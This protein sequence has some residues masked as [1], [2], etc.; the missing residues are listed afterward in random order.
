MPKLR[1]YSRRKRNAGRKDENVYIFIF[2]SV[3]DYEPKTARKRVNCVSPK[4]NRQRHARQDNFVLCRGIQFY[5][6]AYNYLYTLGLARLGNL[7]SEAGGRQIPCVHIFSGFAI[8][9]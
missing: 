1:G 9:S 6:K 4:Y 5:S 2:V 7:A 8:N 3:R